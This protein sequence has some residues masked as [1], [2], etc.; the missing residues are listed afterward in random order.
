MSHLTGHITGNW[1]IVAASLAA[2]GLIIATVRYRIPELSKKVAAMEKVQH[3]SDKDLEMAI[4]SFRTVCKFNQVSCQK[5]VNMEINKVR[6]ELDQKLSALV[7]L[8]NKQAIIIARVDE[9][10]AVLHEKY[11]H[12]FKLPQRVVNVE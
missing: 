12:G 3:P 6:K 8:V 1:P 5:G 2:A 10:V 9:R 4:D 7:D 11:D